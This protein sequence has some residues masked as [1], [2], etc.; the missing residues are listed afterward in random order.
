MSAAILQAPAEAGG[1]WLGHHSGRLEKA[2]QLASERP[3]RQ[4]HLTRSHGEMHVPIGVVGQFLSDL[5]RTAT[6]VSPVMS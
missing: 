4:R 5:S 3:S 6:A 1:D 2:E